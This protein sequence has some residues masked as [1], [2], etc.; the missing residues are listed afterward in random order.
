MGTLFFILLGI[1]VL[2]VFG[3]AVMGLVAQLI[4]W[5]LIGVIIGALARL[6]LPGEQPLGILG[7]AL[8]GAGG[9]LLGGIIANALGVGT[10]IPLVI[11]VLVA[12]V[13]I[14]VLGGMKGGK[15]RPA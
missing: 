1:V 9:A 4:W 5:A 12:A 15:G 10:L 8:Y 13:L 7:T 6:V 11:A 2:V 14:A 3:A